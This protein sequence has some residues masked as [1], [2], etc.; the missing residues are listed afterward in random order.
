[1]RL[2][3]RGESRIR[4]GKGFRRAKYLPSSYQGYIAACAYDTDLHHHTRKMVDFIVDYGTQQ[5]SL[6]GIYQITKPLLEINQEFFRHFGVFTRETYKE[7]TYCYYVIN[8]G[9][10]VLYKDFIQSVKDINN[11]WSSVKL[12][13]EQFVVKSRANMNYGCKEILQQLNDLEA[14]KSVEFSNK[15]TK[16]FLSVCRRTFDL[17]YYIE[18]NLGTGTKFEP[19]G[20]LIRKKIKEGK[21]LAKISSFMIAGVMCMMAAFM[22]D[23]KRPKK[24]K[25]IALSSLWLHL[26]NSFTDK[27]QYYTDSGWFE[28]TNTHYNHELQISN[29]YENGILL[30]VLMKKM[31][32]YSCFTQENEEEVLSVIDKLQNN[33]RKVSQTIQDMSSHAD[34]YSRDIE[35][36]SNE[37]KSFSQLSKDDIIISMLPSFNK[38]NI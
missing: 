24:K 3:G 13:L 17:L 9:A 14:A 12:V 32:G 35:N 30:E 38:S 37:V 36:A 7:Y 1:M 8:L 20:I 4:V 29:F 22:G 5:D 23:C 26:F 18:N 34:Q 6:D 27:I 2:M 33:I 15:F 10:S 19:E 16:M 25:D 31:S 28:I 21:V 11:V